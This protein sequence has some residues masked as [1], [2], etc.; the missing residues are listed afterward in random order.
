[1]FITKQE[2]DDLRKID[3]GRNCLQFKLFSFLLLN[4]LK[5]K[6]IL[7]LIAFYL[8]V[9]FSKVNVESSDA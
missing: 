9:D 5:C 7:F 4:Y 2:I 1:M 8:L 3:Y 6:N